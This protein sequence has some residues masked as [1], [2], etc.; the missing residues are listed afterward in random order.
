[1]KPLFRILAALLLSQAAAHALAADGQAALIAGGNPD[2]LSPHVSAMLPLCAS[3]HGADGISAVG[4]YPNLAG[5][6]A[7]YLVKQL[8][9]FKTRERNDPVMSSMAEPLSPEAIQE[10]AQYF[11]SRK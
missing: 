8:N 2:T 1:M 11:S 6:K 5:Q 7:E 9:A 10:L 4:L 3:C